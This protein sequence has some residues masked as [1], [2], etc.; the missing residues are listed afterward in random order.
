MII[1]SFFWMK[2]RLN[3][4]NRIVIIQRLNSIKLVFIWVILTDKNR[5]NSLLLMNICS[6]N[7][8]YYWFSLIIIFQFFLF[9][10]IFTVWLA[11]KY[12]ICLYKWWVILQSLFSHHHYLVLARSHGFLVFELALYYGLLHYWNLLWT[13][14]I[15]LFW[16]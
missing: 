14:W 3:R 6:H 13:Y 16:K 1:R 11:L 2:N 7:F 12:F 8:Q 9:F 15:T 4:Y 10:K 5:I